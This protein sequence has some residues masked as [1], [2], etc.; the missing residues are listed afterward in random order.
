MRRS[1]EKYL[2]PISVRVRNNRELGRRQDLYS[3][4]WDDGVMAKLSRVK[5]S[6]VGVSE[7]S[8]PEFGIL[9]CRAGAGFNL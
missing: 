1:M 3:F 9:L 7:I 2:F 5:V 4:S 8:S 6:R